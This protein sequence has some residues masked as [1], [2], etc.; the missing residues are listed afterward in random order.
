M[1]EVGT[2]IRATH[3][4]QDLVPAFLECL[5][6]T[7]E[8]PE[9][10]DTLNEEIPSEAMRMLL[11]GDDSHPWWESEDCAWFVHE[12]LFDKL[13]DHAPEGMYFGA[14]EGDGS[15]FGFWKVEEDW[16][17]LDHNVSG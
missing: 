15:D 14:H 4:P 17:E 16:N 5:R 12:E 9:L 13:N 6:F 10:A 11:S 3:R 8:Q 7:C 1:V 2:V